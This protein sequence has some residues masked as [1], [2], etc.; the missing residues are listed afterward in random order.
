MKT[1]NK[2]QKTCQ[3]IPFEPDSPVAESPTVT[4]GLKLLS[5]R[6]KLGPSLG[7]PVGCNEGSS[8]GIYDGNSVGTIVGTL[9]G[10]LLGILLGTIVGV[11][12]GTADGIKLGLEVNNC[13]YELQLYL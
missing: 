9:L 5:I 4:L 7:K 12:L 11:E 10:I 8:V 3:N 6:S 2:K 13:I 1:K